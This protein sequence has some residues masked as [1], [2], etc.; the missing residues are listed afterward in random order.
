M[1]TFFN[2][3]SLLLAT[4]L[5]ALSCTDN[6]RDLSF[7]DT[8]ALPSNVNATYNITQDNTGL[9]TI[10]PS[11]DGAS[12]FNIYFGD[13]TANPTKVDQGKSVNHTYAEGTYSVKI[14]A[15]N[16]K[17]QKTE[18]TQQLIVSFKAPQNL[19]VTIQNDLAVSKK[20]NI[21]AN[22]DFATMFD[23]YSG[24]TGKTAPVVSGNIG[25][26]VSYTYTT[27]G[28]YP[29]RLVAKGAAIA[30]TEYT[31]DFTVT[32]ILQPI[33]S[34]TKPPSR[35]AT[36]VISVYGSEYTNITGVDTFPDWNQGGQGSSWGTFSLNGD[37]MLQYTKLS[38]QGIQFQAAEDLTAMEFIHLDVWTSGDVTRLETSL[39][40]V[41]SGEKPVWTNLTAGQWTS[42]DIPITD[43]TSQ[44]LTVADIHQ[45][46]LV[47]DPWGAGTVFV[48]NIYFYRA[49]TVTA[50]NALPLTF[51][52]LG[53]SGFDGGTTSIVANPDTNGNA[54]SMVMQ[55]VKGSG[56]PWA[57]SKITLDQPFSF[58]GGTQ[59]KVKVWSPR[60]G[61]NLLLKY[62]DSQAW[63]NTLA[64]NEVTVATTVANAWQELTFDMTGVDPNVSY[65]NLV[66]IM[67]NGTQGDGTANYTIYVDDITSSP[68]LD[69]EPKQTLSGFDGG[70]T[71]IVANP[72]TNGNPSAMVLQMV[73][74]AGQPWAGSKITVPR[75][76][77]LTSATT[78]LKVKVWSP[79]AGLNLLLKFE[80]A[81]PWPN[82]AASAEVTVATTKVN[83]WEE[84][85]F[86]MTGID[87]NISYDNLVLIMDNG[88]QGDGSANYTIYVDDISQN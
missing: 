12:Y 81:N 75:P 2:I 58:A 57:G 26:T 66:L 69:F 35:S 19:V 45:L 39:I 41:S 6:L 60:V 43:F 27:A 42:I 49:P 3:R 70:T 8:I 56:Q 46:K 55:M 9:V 87:P 67:D 20:V 73:K 52:D 72:D 29:V 78:T 86:N 5:V 47:G 4:L 33:A 82:T 61:L 50:P 21:T 74:G 76:F 10:T 34:A 65:N 44:G 77:T 48:D 23:F 88:T 40:S 64:S 37:D 59:L 62:E 25:S 51:E 84:L 53:L 36:D 83:Q 1:K 71:S 32:E 30:T 38:Y 31:A 68:L 14:E 15:F 13:N 24:E 28:T 80:D 54:S 63:P 11:A 7:L 79:R 85:T 22:A 16:I 17:D 18:A